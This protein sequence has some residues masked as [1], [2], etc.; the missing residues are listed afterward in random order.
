MNHTVYT[1]WNA[2][3]VVFKNKIPFKYEFMS[4]VQFH[5]VC[6]VMIKLGL[7]LETFKKATGPRCVPSKEVGLSS[8]SHLAV[9]DVIVV[10]M[11]LWYIRFQRRQEDLL[12]DQR[13]FGRPPHRSILKL[14]C[15]Y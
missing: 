1:C 10:K 14:D 3:E 15:L 2:K 11:R 9:V 13:P 4:V 7:L 12:G 8:I 5:V 6:V